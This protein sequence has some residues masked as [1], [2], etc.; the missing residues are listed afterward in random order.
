MEV[1]ILMIDDHPSMIEG[2]KIILSYND[3]GTEIIT[4][5]AYDCKKAYEIITAPKNKFEFDFVFID[6]SL[7]PF[8]EMN[9]FTGE[10]LAIL[11]KEY[12]PTTKIVIL[13]SHTEAILLYE[14][15]KKISPIG[16]LVKS[17]FT[18]DEL[19]HA[20]S[21]MTNYKQ[22]YSET[23]K[24]ILKRFE[25]KDVVLDEVNREIISLLTQGILTKN[26]PSHIGISLSSIEK[27][28]AIIRMFFNLSKGSDEDIIRE[29]KKNGLV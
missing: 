9:I 24:G 1:K 22:Y 4:T 21:L 13:T 10:D 3:L 18:A 7:P 17:D 29:A 19:I 8:E 28:K 14:I 20:F 2:Y 11:A 26:L 16:I 25:P 27:R 15:I 23:V 6:Y 5:A 12:F